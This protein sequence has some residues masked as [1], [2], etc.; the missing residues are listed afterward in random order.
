MHNLNVPN[1][2]IPKKLLLVFAH[3]LFTNYSSTRTQN[4]VF[5][6]TKFMEFLY[7]Y[8]FNFKYETKSKST[9]A[10]HCFIVAKCHRIFNIM[11]VIVNLMRVTWFTTDLNSNVI[12]NVNMNLNLLWIMWIAICI[13]I[14]NHEFMIHENTPCLKTLKKTIVNG[15]ALWGV[16][17][18]ALLITRARKIVT[19]FHNYSYEIVMSLVI[20]N[21]YENA[22]NSYQIVK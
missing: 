4:S 13:F 11:H 9:T 16:T 22:H 3:V 15:V 18:R 10:A 1:N 17:H 8:I 12:V 6:L 7:E 5:F 14:I 2:C 19:K 21:S 20:V